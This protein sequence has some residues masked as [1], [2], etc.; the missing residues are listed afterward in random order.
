MKKM[1]LL[2]KLNLVAILSS[3]PVAAGSSKYVFSADR[4]LRPITDCL[5]IDNYSLS[6][7]VISMDCQKSLISN[8]ILCSQGRMVGVYPTI[9]ECQEARDSLVATNGEHPFSTDH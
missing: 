5:A 7:I 8:I 2:A 3:L 9:K 1:L 6:A 4:Q